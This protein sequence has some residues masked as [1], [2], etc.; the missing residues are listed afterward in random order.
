MA[1]SAIVSLSD[2]FLSCVRQAKFVRIAFQWADASPLR[3]NPLR[4]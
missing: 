1:G 4:I 2:D 3:P